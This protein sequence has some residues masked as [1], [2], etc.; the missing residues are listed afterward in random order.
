MREGNG[1]ST[2][3]L[4][5]VIKSN[6]FKEKNEE[7]QNKTIVKLYIQNSNWFLG[8]FGLLLSFLPLLGD[9]GFTP[10]SRD[11]PVHPSLLSAQHQELEQTPRKEQ[12]ADF[13]HQL[14]FAL[15]GEGSAAI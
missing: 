2:L 14:G 9:T 13:P 8:G 1:V 15:V 11:L 10:H 6:S 4:A 12:R 7:N 3:G 5:Q